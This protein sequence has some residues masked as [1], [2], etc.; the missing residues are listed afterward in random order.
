M[1]ARELGDDL[2]ELHNSPF[3]AYDLNYLDVVYAVAADPNHKL[4][5]HR[6]ERRSGHR[7]L[8]VQFADATPK[9]QR[10]LHLKDL[11]KFSVAWEGADQ[12]L[13]SLDISEPGN[14]QPVCDHLWEWE[15]LGLLEYE[16]CEARVP[17]SFDAAP[18]DS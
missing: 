3:Y 17:G 12:T 15:K 6:V 11:D 2:Y 13:S 16:T 1:W 14:Y 7:T 5:V 18:K 9:L 4:L 10:D 8:R